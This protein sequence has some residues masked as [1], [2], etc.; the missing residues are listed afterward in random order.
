MQSQPRRSRGPEGC[1]RVITAVSRDDGSGIADRDSADRK[2]DYLSG[3]SAGQAIRGRTRRQG[4]YKN[5]LQ[6]TPNAHTTLLISG[7]RFSV[8][9]E[10]D[11]ATS[12][13]R[14]TNFNFWKVQRT[15]LNR[16]WRRERW[17]LR[18]GTCPLIIAVTLGSSCHVWNQTELLSEFENSESGFLDLR[19]PRKEG[20]SFALYNSAQLKQPKRVHKEKIP[21]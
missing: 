1:L 9:S 13:S 7:R 16:K 10:R 2:L 17:G 3:R 21:Q 8:K 20:R 15:R 12:Q 5:S 6:V 14:C 18:C 11:E 4:R 19:V